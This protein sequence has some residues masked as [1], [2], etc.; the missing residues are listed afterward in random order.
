MKIEKN[1]PISNMVENSE[2]KRRIELPTTDKL[3]IFEH[4]TA[5]HDSFYY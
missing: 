4:G 5:T 2:S 3:E 1:T